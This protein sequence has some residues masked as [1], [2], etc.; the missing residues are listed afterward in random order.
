LIFTEL[1]KLNLPNLASSEDVLSMT[2]AWC[3][4]R[5][6]NF[7]YLTK[8]NKAAGRSFNDLMQYPV[9]P[10]VLADY[11][12]QILDLDNLASYRYWL[13]CTPSATWRFS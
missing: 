6:G 13:L 10:F 11:T 1:S 7:E 2:K 9:M 4:G 3:S 8:L 12:S 5:I